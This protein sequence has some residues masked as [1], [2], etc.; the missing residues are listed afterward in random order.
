MIPANA[1]FVDIPAT[2]F[3]LKPLAISDSSIEKGTIS[4]M[5]QRTHLFTQT[6][7]GAV[8]SL[9]LYEDHSHNMNELVLVV[10]QQYSQSDVSPIFHPCSI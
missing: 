5:L 10:E 1:L 9:R 3:R 8:A 4:K 7:A 2:I 6:P